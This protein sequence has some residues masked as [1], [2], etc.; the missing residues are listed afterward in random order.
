MEVPALRFTGETRTICSIQSVQAGGHGP[1][2]QD[3]LMTQVGAACARTG[4]VQVLYDTA[5]CFQ[6]SARATLPHRP[7]LLEETVTPSLH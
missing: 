5:A 6:F 7:V 2:T 3:R 4:T 1:S